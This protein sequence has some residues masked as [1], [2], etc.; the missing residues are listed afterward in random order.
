V[1]GD[2]SDDSISVITNDSDEEFKPEESLVR[3]ASKFDDSKRNDKATPSRIER[4]KRRR[5]DNEA[6]I[7]NGPDVGG[8][9]QTQVQGINQSDALKDAI[10]LFVYSLSTGEYER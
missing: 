4:T 10:F 9:P 6:Y 8:N 7:T 3:V 5:S 2:D 1:S